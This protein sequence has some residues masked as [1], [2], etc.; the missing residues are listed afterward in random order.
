MLARLPPQ[1]YWPRLFITCGGWLAND[2]AF[3]GNKLFQSKFIAVISPGASRFKQMQV[4]G[5]Q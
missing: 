5:G 2:A 3:Y 4:S 1:H